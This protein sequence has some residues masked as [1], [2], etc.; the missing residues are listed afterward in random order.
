MHALQDE[1][2]IIED[3]SHYSCKRGQEVNATLCGKVGVP[4]ECQGEPA[5]ES[6]EMSW[7]VPGVRCAQ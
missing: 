4:P 6:W 3:I 2:V 5:D 7:P 1:V